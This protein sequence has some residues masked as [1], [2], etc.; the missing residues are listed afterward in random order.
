LQIRA[1]ADGRLPL[2]Q[3]DVSAS[4]VAV[5]ARLY[6]E[7]PDNGFLPSTGT[8]A[9]LHLTDMVRVDAGVAAGMAITPFYD[10]MIAK[11]IAS[12]TTRDEAYSRLTEALRDCSVSGVTTNLSFLHRIVADLDV[13]SNDVHTGTIDAMMAASGSAVR[14]PLEVHIAAGLWLW[15]QKDRMLCGREGLSAWRLGVG[16][17]EVATAP[18]VRL[19]ASGQNYEVTFGHAGRRDGLVVSIDGEVRTLDFH[20]HDNG[21]IQV[22]CDGLT[23]AVTPLL[24]DTFAGFASPVAS[25]SFEVRPYLSGTL[26]AA[27][28]AGDGQ[29]RAPMMGRIV[30]VRVEQGQLVAAGDVLAVMESMKMEL[31]IVAPLA[32]SVAEIDCP[33]GTTVER[34]QVVFVLTPQQEQAA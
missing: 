14:H 11:L 16:T 8:I 2:T 9:K 27:V 30:S 12:G 17:T 10:P 1:V 32:G 3:A 5:E 13:L 24:S 33:T 6:A 18:A 26:L 23:I 34:D 22:S 21:T 15:A 20:A 29:V 4:G 25:A 7:D 31:T 28:G 19:I